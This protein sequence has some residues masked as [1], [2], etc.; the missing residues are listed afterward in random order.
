V[1]ARS[2]EVKRESKRRSAEIGF[3]WSLRAIKYPPAQGLY[4]LYFAAFRII[5]NAQAEK[6][7]RIPRFFVKLRRNTDTLS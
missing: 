6:V 3:G 4:W 5:L 1:L 7:K 2:G